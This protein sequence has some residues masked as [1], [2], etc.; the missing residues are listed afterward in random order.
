MTGSENRRVKQATRL[1]TTPVLIIYLVNAEEKLP[2]SIA[3]GMV[4]LSMSELVFLLSLGSTITG[5]MVK[6]NAV[7]VDPDPR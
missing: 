6:A 1:A 7:P 4:T 2:L 5:N 3:I